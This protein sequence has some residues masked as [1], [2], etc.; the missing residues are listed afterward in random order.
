M[1]LYQIQINL[2]YLSMIAVD[3]KMI[4]QI[5]NKLRALNNKIKP[6]N[7]QSLINISCQKTKRKFFKSDRVKQISNQN[8][9][10]KI[11]LN[12]LICKV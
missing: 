10:I 4:C 6:K 7:F 5:I 8:K 3:F 2:I 9:L 11:I 12:L 1:S